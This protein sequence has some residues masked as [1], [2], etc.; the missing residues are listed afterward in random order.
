ME[1]YY[2]G[3]ISQVAIQ[4]YFRIDTWSISIGLTFLSH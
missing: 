3:A 2:L 1:Y 4:F